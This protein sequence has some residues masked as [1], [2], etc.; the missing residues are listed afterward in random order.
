[1]SSPGRPFRVLYVCTGNICR[2]AVAERLLRRDLEARLGARSE[3]VQVDS[4]GVRGLVGEPIDADSAAALTALGGDPAGFAARRLDAELVQGADL[5]LTANRKH[6]ANVVRLDPSAARRTFTMRELA[7]LAGLVDLDALPASDPRAR[8]EAAVREVAAAR[9]SV[10]PD[11]RHDLDVQDPY[12]SPPAVHR[13]TT[14]AIAATSSVTAGLLAAA[15]DPGLAAS[16]AAERAARN[17]RPEV[18]RAPPATPA[19]GGRSRAWRI[20]LLVVAGLLL[21]LLAA[22]AWLGW[23]GLRAKQELD[24]AQPLVGQVRTAVLQGDT[25]RT[26]SLVAEL[27]QHT[28]AA[29]SRTGGPVWSLA[30]HLPAYGDDMSAVRQ[31]TVSVDDVARQV[32][33]PLVGVAGTVRP[34]DLR[35]G[36]DRI[37]L[38]PLRDAEP[39]LT[40]ALA[41]SLRVQGDVASID[42]TGL[43]PQVRSAV[44]E[45]RGD[46]TQLVSTTRAG[47]QAAR[48]LPPM[49]GADGPRRYLLAFQTNAEVRGTGGLLGA[50]GVLEADDGVVRLRRLGSN[51]E[52]EDPPRLPVKLGPDFTQLYGQAPRLWVNANASAHFPYAAQIWLA[53]WQHQH[54]QR[55]DGVIATDP[56][57]LGYLLKATGPVR[58]P[59]GNEVTSE[60]AARLMLSDVYARY[61]S[62][63]DSDA[64]DLYLQSVASAVFDGILSGQGDPQRLADELANAARDR[65]LLVYSTRP[66]EQSTLVRTAVSGTIPDTA[67]PLLGVVVNSGVAS[68]L[69]YYLRRTVSWTS[70]GCGSAG[71]DSRV[72]VTL[73]NTAP[74]SGLPEY[75]APK[76]GTQGGP[77][78]LATL[79][80]GTDYLLVNVLTTRG[81]LLRSATVDG[82]PGTASVGAERGHPVF[83]FEMAIRPGQ[84]RTLTLDLLSPGAH[85]GKAVVVDQ[86]LATAAPPAEVALARC[87]RARG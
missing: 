38:Q 67:A 1:V 69:D 19:P 32:L 50:Y 77:A 37:A 87:S 42:T 65:R 56:V 47:E 46:V 11:D 54:G 29:R 76:P 20:A 33:P 5:I 26:T 18:R 4:A 61:P 53:S 14:D 28:A 12:G 60:N 3:L 23:T 17:V 48:L 72:V 25:T 83:G 21:L 7:W 55:L 63:D 6:R 30:A 75:V 64:R 58:L 44:S 13:Q 80:R 71:Q 39:A 8:L 84:K 2:S 41:R 45:L 57:A 51:S 43:V 36:R 82:Q 34:E 59:G 70:T 9:G 24:D 66:G 10:R 15:A 85:R 16:V 79:P 81:T 62:F 52:L 73:T 86:P 27:Q 31:M 68:K 49:L 74:R 22:A 35:T 40:A 78:V